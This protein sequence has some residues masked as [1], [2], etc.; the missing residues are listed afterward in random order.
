M[1]QA[2]YQQ[3][4]ID[5]SKHPCGF[6][7]SPCG[8]CESAKNPM[9]GDTINLCVKRDG[10]II[11][12]IQ[13][14]ASGC[15]ISIAAASV[16]VNTMKGKTVAQ[17][18]R[19]MTQYLRMLK[20]ESYQDLPTKLASFSGVCKYPMRVKCASFAWHACAEALEKA[21]PI[22]LSKAV[23]DYWLKCVNQSQGVGILLDFK[24][25][26]C[27]GWQFLPKVISEE[28]E[29]FYEFDGLKVFLDNDLLPQIKGTKIDY[30]INDLGEGKV[31]YQHPDAKLHC[32][33]GESFFMESS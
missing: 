19:T 11:T 3:M 9:C 29:T 31:V 10:D 12:D 26:G 32:G 1:S 20:G 16:L 24:Q 18:Q 14:D 28:C 33:C 4:I 5:H 17:F 2:L 7:K 23:I 13:F 27:M 6:T 21:K 25:V 30:E 15:S 22:Q 8:C